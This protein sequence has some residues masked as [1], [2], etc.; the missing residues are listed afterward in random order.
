M[1][2]AK[3]EGHNGQEKHTLLTTPS[4]ELRHDSGSETFVTLTYLNVLMT[5]E[6]HN[7]YNQFYST[8]FLS[9]LYVSNESS[10]SSSE[11]QHN[12]LYYTVWRAYLLAARLAC[13]IVI[14]TLQY[15]ARYTQRQT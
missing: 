3:N 4:E 1:T 13:T 7:S 9:A 15:D 2:Y 5:N 6:M 10:H 8:V 11:A 14:N 12:I